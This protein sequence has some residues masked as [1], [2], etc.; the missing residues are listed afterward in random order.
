MKNE[1]VTPEAEHGLKKNE[2]EKLNELKTQ[3][4]KHLPNPHD[5]IGD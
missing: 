2:K 3:R 4:G 5:I 1:N